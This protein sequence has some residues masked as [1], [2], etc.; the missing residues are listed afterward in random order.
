MLAPWCVYSDDYYVDMGDHIFPVTKYRQLYHRL[1]AQGILRTEQTVTP[2]PA[3]EA[4]LLLVHRPEYLT[5]LR[6]I[7]SLG[8]GYL[9]PDTPVSPEI[10]EKAILAAGGTIKAARLALTQG[11]SL[12]LSGGFHHA[13]PDH[14]EGFCYLNDI[15]IAVRRLQKEGT[16]K[17]AAI[18]DCD[19]HQGNGTAA[20]FSH[21]NT[22]FTFSIHEEDNYP[23]PKLPSDLDI[24]LPSGCGDEQYLQGVRTGLEAALA[25]PPDIVFYLAGADPF[26]EDLLGGLAVTMKGLQQRDSTILDAC[27]NAKVPVCVLLAGGYA[28]RT[29]DTVTIHFETACK[30]RTLLDRLN[31]CQ[32]A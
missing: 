1:L 22:V 4:D 19:V 17:T 21:D 6:R 14:G 20:I 29:A 18:L 10:L 11:L 24:G 15:A 32:P 13:F 28:R 5:Q 7:A 12:H 16:V 26:R 9:T 30:I 8:W 31:H 3:S 25:T 27:V 23:I 2:R